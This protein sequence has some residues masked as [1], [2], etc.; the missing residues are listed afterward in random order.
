MSA[1]KVLY[2]S[3]YGAVGPQPATKS[4]AAERL[5]TGD[6]TGG[7]VTGRQARERMGD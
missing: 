6:V 3:L 1:L 2:V 5:V 7:G 4:G